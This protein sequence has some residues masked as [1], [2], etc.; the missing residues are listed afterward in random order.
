[1]SGPE[2]W[3]QLAVQL[4]KHVLY[5]VVVIIAVL[6][7]TSKSFRFHMHANRQDH[8]PATRKVL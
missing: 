6:Q 5:A 7:L 1:M 8:S 4:L 2:I 3:G